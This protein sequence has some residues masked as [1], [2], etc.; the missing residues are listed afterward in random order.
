M[1]ESAR[2]ALGE[3]KEKAGDATGDDR[4]KREGQADQA[5]EHVKKGVDKAVD[6]VKD[7]NRDS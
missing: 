5:G 6:K 1:P 3:V 7:L 2:D 4:L